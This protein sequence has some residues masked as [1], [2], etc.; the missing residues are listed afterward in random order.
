M[1]YSDIFKARKLVEE[2]FD[3]I[4]EY[5]EGKC[6]GGFSRTRR[7]MFLQDD[8]NR[9]L[10]RGVASSEFESCLLSI[11]VLIQTEADGISC[12]AVGSNPAF[13]YLSVRLLPVVEDNSKKGIS[14]TKATGVI[15]IFDERSNE[16][17]LQ[18]VIT[19]EIIEFEKPVQPMLRVTTE[20]F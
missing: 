1:A 8:L 10:K 16:I 20:I 19:V 18:V 17:F 7:M 13:E 2:S 4:K 14:P 11:I 3:D 12:A 15:C 6:S 9:F 5:V